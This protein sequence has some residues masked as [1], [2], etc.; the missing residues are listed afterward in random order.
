MSFT[1]NEADL[2]NDLNRLRF[3]IGD[4][5][6]DRQ[7]LQDEEI[8]KIISDQSTLFLQAA[9]GCRNICAK[10]AGENDHKIGSDSEKLSQIYDHYLQLAEMFEKKSSGTP[11]AGG[12]Y[13]ADKTTITDDSSLVTP[14]FKRGIHDNR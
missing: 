12:V 8:T 14:S 4:T 6:E 7:L 13:T 9:T 5:N 2:G 1:Y 10:Y 11:W 3:E